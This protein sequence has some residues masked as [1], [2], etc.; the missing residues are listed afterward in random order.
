M[1]ETNQ[2]TPHKKKK[3]S[4]INT[5]VRENLYRGAQNT[6]KHAPATSSLS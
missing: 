4:C 1:Y 6:E 3:I 2:F 5:T